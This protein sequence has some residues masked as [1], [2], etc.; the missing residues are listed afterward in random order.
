MRMDYTFGK[1]SKKS[2]KLSQ[3]HL[4]LGIPTNIAVGP[5]GFR[6]GLESGTGRARRLWLPPFSSM[7]RRSPRM[8]LDLSKL[9]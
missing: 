9:S 8:D 5:L 3:Q 4:S 1:K 7:S 6:A 2:L